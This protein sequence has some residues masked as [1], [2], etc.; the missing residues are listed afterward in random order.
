M[1][2]KLQNWRLSKLAINIDMIPLNIS[3][4]YSINLSIIFM[5]KALADPQTGS[6]IPSP[7]AKISQ[8][9]NL[10]MYI[11]NWNWVYY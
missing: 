6:V 11:L 9:Q 2:L 1:N 4:N 8:S 5:R 3:T 7:T 10:G